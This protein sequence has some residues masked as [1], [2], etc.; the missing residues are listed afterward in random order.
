[1]TSSKVPA[2]WKDK[3]DDRALAVGNNRL[4][5]PEWRSSQQST[6]EGAAPPSASAIK[7]AR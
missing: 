5:R 7:P 6:D 3:A 2:A 1:M 4:L